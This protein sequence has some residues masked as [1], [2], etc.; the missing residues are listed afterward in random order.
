MAFKGNLP[1]R[2]LITALMAVAFGQGCSIKEDRALCPCSFFLDFSGVDPE[3]AEMSEIRIEAADG[4]LYY[5]PEVSF[6]A[7]QDKSGSA[8]GF[9]YGVSVPKTSVSV[10]VINGAG[11]F[12]SSDSRILIPLGEECPPVY[13]HY[14]KLDLQAE[15]YRE[16]VVLH[17]D[18]CTINIRMLKDD[19]P[20]PFDVTVTGNINSI[21]EDRTVSPGDFSFTVTPQPD[22]TAGVRVPRQTD[23]S[24]MLL[25][26]EEDKVLREFALGEYIAGAGY[27]WTAEDLDDVDI[28]IDYAHAE[29]HVLVSDW[30]GSYEFD[31]VI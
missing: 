29:I 17:K 5:D 22:G 14:S 9:L 28:S 7:G 12:S 18:F 8:E 31:V 20:Y 27:D 25:I 10:S 6:K 26:R 15:T 3:L 21:N 1:S 19:S 23:N 24:L 11:A 13:M 16:L 30:S 2:V 4:F